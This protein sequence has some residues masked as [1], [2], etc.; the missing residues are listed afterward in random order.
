MEQAVLVQEVP[1]VPVALAVQPRL[2]WPV[3]LVVRA[4]RV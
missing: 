1:V 2:Y 3:V 4:L